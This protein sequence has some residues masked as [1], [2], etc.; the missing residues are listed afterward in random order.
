MG[1]HMK[2]QREAAGYTP[3]I[4]LPLPYS[5]GMLPLNRNKMPAAVW[6]LRQAFYMSNVYCTDRRA[7]KDSKWYTPAKRKLLGSGS[8]GA[9]RALRHAPAEF[10]HSRNVRPRD[11]V[12]K[13]GRFMQRRTAFCGKN[14]RELVK[15]NL[16]ERTQGE[17]QFLLLQRP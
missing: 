13:P 10:R 17:T 2:E 14:S 4:Y 8:G 7:A 9:L 3:G 16:P 12:Y 1:L 11:F 5:A 15:E 6:K